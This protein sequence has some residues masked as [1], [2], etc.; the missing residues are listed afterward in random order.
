MAT[1]EQKIATVLQL[2]EG[3]RNIQ[4]VESIQKEGLKA[5]KRCATLIEKRSGK[6]THESLVACIAANAATLEALPEPW[7]V[8]KILCGSRHLFHLLNVI[9]I[10]QEE[11]WNEWSAFVARFEEDTELLLLASEL[12]RQG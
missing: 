7:I 9:D 5:I 8:D 3:A 6:Y 1:N 4:I 10:T 2:R 12:A 11:G